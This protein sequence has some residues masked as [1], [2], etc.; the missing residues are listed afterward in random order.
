MQIEWDGVL[1]IG[2]T[3]FRPDES[4]DLEATQRNLE[5]LIGAGAGGIVALGRF[6]EIMSLTRAER[7]RVVEATKEVVRGRVPLLSGC[8]ETSPHDAFAY[9]REMERL[10]I[11]GDMIPGGHMAA[12]S[13]PVELAD[14]LETYLRTLT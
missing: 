1:F 4:L 2:A 14:Q 5:T 10:G 11:D 3:Q 6:G 9:A 13:H 12:L 7:R 8:I